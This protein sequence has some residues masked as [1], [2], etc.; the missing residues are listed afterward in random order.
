MTELWIGAI[1]ATVA[2][3][4]YAAWGPKVLLGTIF[5]TIVFVFVAGVLWLHAE[6]QSQHH[7]LITQCSD[8]PGQPYNWQWKHY[9]NPADCRK[10]GGVPYADQYPDEYKKYGGK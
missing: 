7:E 8:I 6:T 9:E 2:G 10:V 3:C 5:G 1:V 4:I